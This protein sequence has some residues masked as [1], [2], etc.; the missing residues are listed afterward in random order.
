MLVLNYTSLGYT[1]SRLHWIYGADGSES[2]IIFTNN[3][4]L[5]KFQFLIL[6]NI[7]VKYF[8]ILYF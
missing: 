1:G 3:K 8:I 2:Q 6:F 4:S 7:F 5:C